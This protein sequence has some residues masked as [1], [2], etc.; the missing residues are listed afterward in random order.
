MFGEKEIE[1]L[2]IDDDP[3]D[4]EIFGEAVSLT[5]LKAHI[6]NVKNDVELYAYFKSSLIPHVIFLDGSV[7]CHYENNC[8]EEIK[9][10]QHLAEIPVVI[11]STIGMD[12]RVNNMYERGAVLFL[13]KPASLSELTNILKTTLTIDWRKADINKVKQDYS[14]KYPEMKFPKAISNL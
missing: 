9:A 5:G 14:E 3:D 11:L 12:N 6:K 8:L 10:Q 1:I 7:T 4:V 13:I 2:C